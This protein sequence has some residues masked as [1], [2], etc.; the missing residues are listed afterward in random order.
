MTTLT[1]VIS[2]TKKGIISS[3]TTLT[4]LILG[5]ITNYT[6]DADIQY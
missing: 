4:T 6:D 5:T 2:D 1:A 3:M